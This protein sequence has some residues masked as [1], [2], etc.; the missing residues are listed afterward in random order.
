MGKEEW[1][2]ISKDD[3]SIERNVKVHEKKYGLCLSLFTS[4]LPC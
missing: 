1:E 4:K 3:V 2:L